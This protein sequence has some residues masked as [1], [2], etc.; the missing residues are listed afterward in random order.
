MCLPYLRNFFFSFFLV[1]LSW[2]DRLCL[3]NSP[4]GKKEIMA[5]SFRP[6]A[7]SGSVWELSRDYPRNVSL[8]LGCRL[9][10][11]EFSRCSCGCYYFPVVSEATEGTLR[12]EGKTLGRL[13]WLLLIHCCI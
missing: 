5:L 11:T 1:A 12:P 2:Q 4:R 3:S 8:H 6:A 10:R 7:D 9:N 13:L